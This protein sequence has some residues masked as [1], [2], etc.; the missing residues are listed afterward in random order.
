MSSDVS[1][2]ERATAFSLTCATL[3]D[4]GIAVTLPLRMAQVRATAVARSGGR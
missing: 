2:N 4:S 3:P 1:A